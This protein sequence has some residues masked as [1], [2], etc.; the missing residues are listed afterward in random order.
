MK[1]AIVKLSAL[2]DIIHTAFILQFIKAQVPHA[3]IDW[4]VEEGFAQ[5]L[6][7]NPDIHAIK[8]VNLKSIKKQKSLLLSEIK[9]IK[10]YAKA[11][12]DLV[13]DFQGLLKSAI[14]ARLLGRDVAGFDKNSTREGVAA[15]LYHKSFTIAYHDNTIDRYRLLA[16]KAL[17]IPI[18]K[19]DVK[20]KKPYMHFLPH[21]FD[22]AKPYFSHDKPNVIFIIGANWQ[23]RI[24]PKEQLLEVAQG[25]D[26]NILIPYG[27]E[28]EK[29]M[30]TWLE[31][32]AT[33]ITLLPKMNLNALK[34]TISHAD[35][36]IGNDTGPSFIA[37]ANNIPAILLF[38]PTPPSRV[39][40]SDICIT[41]KSSSP[42]NHYKLNREDFSIKEIEPS[43]ILSHAKALLS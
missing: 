16:S 17:D 34:A 19:E 31:T 1:I 23:S 4:I 2:G 11:E 35:L 28:A 8:T 29:E 14:S 10:S 41:L 33:N 21:D 13:I 15:Y 32:H 24:Y 26:A 12:Y 20:E 25:L 30:G 39:Y 36:L 43:T 5:I 6:E 3:Q 38:G 22:I 37:W 18:H 9:K 27:T 40:A 7:H 42:I